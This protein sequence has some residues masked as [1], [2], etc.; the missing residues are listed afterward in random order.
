MGL[1]FEKV[2]SHKTP[3]TFNIFFFLLFQCQWT[4]AARR[5][6]DVIMDPDGFSA[7]DDDL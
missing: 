3:I 5:H 7:A 1:D 2:N 6:P 4:C